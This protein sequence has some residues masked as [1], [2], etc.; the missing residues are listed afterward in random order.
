[1]IW[2]NPSA[3]LAEFNRDF[4]ELDLPQRNRSKDAWL[5]L[6]PV[7]RAPKGHARRNHAAA[8][9]RGPKGVYAPNRLPCVATSESPK[10]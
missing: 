2:D 4:N 7:S 9:A 10:G 3:T 5:L 6:L 1:M 8:L